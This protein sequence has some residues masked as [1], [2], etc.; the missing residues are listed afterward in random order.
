MQGMIAQFVQK[1]KFYQQYNKQTI[2]YGQVPPK[3]VKH[4]TSLEEVYVVLIGPWNV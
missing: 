2:K 1:C 3:Q 4:L